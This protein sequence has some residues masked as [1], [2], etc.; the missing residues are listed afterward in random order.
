MIAIHY[1]IALLILD[2]YSAIKWYTGSEEVTEINAGL[3]SQHV[4][5]APVAMYMHYHIIVPMQGVQLM[6]QWLDGNLHDF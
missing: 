4:Q 5:T 1:K 3:D 6:P 2:R